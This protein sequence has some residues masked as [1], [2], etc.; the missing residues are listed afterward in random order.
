MHLCTCV[1]EEGGDGEG[2][3]SEAPSLLSY[4]LIRRMMMILLQQNKRRRESGKKNVTLELWCTV[5]RKSFNITHIMYHGTWCVL[6]WKPDCSGIKTKDW[7]RRGG[8]R[9]E[10][11]KRGRGM[12]DRVDKS[13]GI[14]T[15]IARL[16]RTGCVCV[17]DRWLVYFQQNKK[18]RKPKVKIVT[19]QLCGV[20]KK[21]YSLYENLNSQH[22]SIRQIVEEKRRG[23]EL[24]VV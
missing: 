14:V 24:R 19:L 22:V 7:L 1:R 12:K 5:S 6:C 15:R 8:T 4:T 16:C 10:L 9:R 23:K 21:W 2:A 17:W 11:K 18:R 13:M 20:R 3:D